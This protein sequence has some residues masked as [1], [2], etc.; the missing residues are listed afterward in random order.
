MLDA[1]LRQ[2]QGLD[3]G[4]R[5]LSAGA[6]EPGQEGGVSRTMSWCPGLGRE[7]AGAEAQGRPC[8][9]TLIFKGP[10]SPHSFS[11][12][13]HL[14]IARRSR[15]DSQTRT[16]PSPGRGARSHSHT[17]MR[18]TAPPCPPPPMLADTCPSAA[19]YWSGSCKPTTSISCTVIHTE[20]GLNRA[21]PCPGS[22]TLGGALTLGAAG[23]HPCPRCETEKGPQLTRL[24][25]FWVS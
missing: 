21:L 8:S 19:G 5:L 1:I 15:L 10:S 17:C 24:C 11:F 20:V 4:T 2:E 14:G 7:E 13:E 3:G 16:V 9:S 22:A 18:I 25:G 6:S 12:S 23:S